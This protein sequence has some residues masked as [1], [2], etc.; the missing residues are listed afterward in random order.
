PGILETAVFESQSF[1]Q[2]LELDSVC[3]PP[4]ELFEDQLDYEP[5]DEEDV[6]GGSWEDP[7]ARWGDKIV[8]WDA[9]HPFV[10]INVSLPSLFSG[11]TSI[12]I[13]RPAGFGFAGIKTTSF[14]LRMNERIRIKAELYKLKTSKNDVVLQ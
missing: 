14:P 3:R 4:R 1:W 9:D 10:G 12:K 7:R 8:A 5:L 13:T 2:R 6:Q 11:K